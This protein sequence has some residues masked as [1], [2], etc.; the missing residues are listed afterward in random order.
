MIASPWD[1]AIRR[2]FHDLVALVDLT[3]EAYGRLLPT[4]AASTAEVRVNWSLRWD[5]N[6]TFSNE[7][8]RSI[9]RLAT[10]TKRT[11]VL[12]GLGRFALSG[13]LTN[14]NAYDATRK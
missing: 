4:A 3:R 12:T 6:A 5:C 7:N 9:P 1:S 13:A 2:S 14:G 11:T 8:I 10:N